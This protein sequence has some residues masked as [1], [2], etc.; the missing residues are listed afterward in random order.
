MPEAAVTITANLPKVVIEID[1]SKVPEE[2]RNPRIVGEA[3]MKHLTI[4]GQFQ[5]ISAR[6]GFP[7]EA[8]MEAR[9]RAAKVLLDEAAE[10]LERARLDFEIAE[11][12]ARCA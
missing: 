11:A 9:E 2:V 5:E 10:L 4:L 3:A 7:V 12:V 8:L 6:T 1:W